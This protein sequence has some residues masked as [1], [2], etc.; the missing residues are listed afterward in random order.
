MDTI[1]PQVWVSQCALKSPLIPKY[2]V[3]Y[4]IFFFFLCCCAELFKT[5]TQRIKVYTVNV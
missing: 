2:S 4:Q 3:Y 1:S 5:S